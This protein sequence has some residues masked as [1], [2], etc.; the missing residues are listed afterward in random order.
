[1][2]SKLNIP[3]ISKGN[4]MSEG[5]Q[6]LIGKRST[7]KTKFMG[8]DIEIH[9]LNVSEV[10][11]IQALAKDGNESEEAGFNVLKLVIRKGVT[12]AESLDDDS[13]DGFPVDELSKLSREIMKFSGLDEGK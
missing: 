10:R 12:G 3:K 6:A 13:F 4:E 7:K 9:K 1:M 2:T 8:Q 11:E 5:L